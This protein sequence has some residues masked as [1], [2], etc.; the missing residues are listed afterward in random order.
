MEN[1]QSEFELECMIINS[2][3]AVKMWKKSNK[4][5]PPRLF[6]LPYRCLIVPVAYVSK[7]GHC[8]AFL[9]AE[10]KYTRFA[11][12]SA[13]GTHSHASSALIAFMSHSHMKFCYHIMVY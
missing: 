10:S 2:E 6:I 9:T 11:W 8:V 3:V 12:P 7:K 13:T 4:A 5:L 1:K